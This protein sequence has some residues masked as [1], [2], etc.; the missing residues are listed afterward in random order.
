MVASE[1]LKAVQFWNV[2]SERLQEIVNNSAADINALALK[3]EKG[4]LTSHLSLNGQHNRSPTMAASYMD[5]QTF[6]TSVYGD[7]GTGSYASHENVDGHDIPYMDL[8]PAP[9]DISSLQPMSEAGYSAA[10]L[11]EPNSAEVP[12]GSSA[13][14][15]SLLLSIRGAAQEN[16]FLQ[17][18]DSR[19]LPSILSGSD[20][21]NQDFLQLPKSQGTCREKLTKKKDDDTDWV[22]NPKPSPKG[23]TA[24]KSRSASKA[25]AALKSSTVARKPEE[26]IP[27]AENALND[28]ERECAVAKTPQGLTDLEEDMTDDPEPQNETETAGPTEV[29]VIQTRKA[30]KKW[31]ECEVCLK[32][33]P[34][35]SALTAHM[36]TH[37]KPFNCTECGACFSSKS[38]L[39]VHQRK[40]SGEKPYACSMCNATFSTQ[41]NLKRHVKTHSGERPWECSQ[42]D[43]RFTEKKTLMVHMRRHT[44]EKPFQCHI[45]QRSFAQKGILQSHLAMHLGQK[46]HLCEHCGKAF[47]QRSQL[48]LHTLRHQGVRKFSC[49]TCPAKFLTKGDLERHNRTHTGER[50]FVCDICG[51]TFTRQQSLTEHT[52]RHYGVKPYECTHCGKTYAEMS[53]CYKHIKHHV[54]AG[55]I[56]GDLQKGMKV[57][58][59][60]KMAIFV[61]PG[62][63]DT[64][65]ENSLEG[66]DMQPSAV[67][68]SEVEG[69]EVEQPEG[70]PQENSPCELSAEEAVESTSMSQLTAMSLLT[71]TTGF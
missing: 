17:G 45:C 27:A 2:V 49:S 70:E 12:N 50:P 71:T 39:V 20:R 57:N 33:V 42:C 37:R 10:A 41:G 65:V 19:S 67:I 28:A 43:S 59:Q 52:N 32:K 26:P 34:T 21:S 46:A 62:H 11:G 38:N 53:A 63:Q 29:I 60:E 47:R 61:N 15:T 13:G 48:R 54:K 9:E 6:P 30:Q 25:T 4:G 64:V 31:K 44:G 1:K 55:E 5:S 69:S 18:A 7:G 22:P 58:V 8:P 3:M 66:A 36:W 14:S 23:K 56:V 51:K 16:S 68:S 35:K 40:H 24:N